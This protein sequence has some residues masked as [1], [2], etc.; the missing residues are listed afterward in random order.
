MEVYSQQ[1]GPVKLEK[2]TAQHWHKQFNWNAKEKWEDG[3]KEK[4]NTLL[5]GEM[6]TGKREWRTKV[7]SSEID[8]AT[9]LLKRTFKR[10][11]FFYN[12]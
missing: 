12:F 3:T 10:N 4:K 6:D 2:G 5:V 11:Y 9:I 8:V 1:Q 7:W